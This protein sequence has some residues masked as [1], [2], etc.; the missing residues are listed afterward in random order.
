[1]I[2]RPAERAGLQL[3]NGLV[4]RILDDTGDESGNLALMVY[5]LDELYK[6]SGEGYIT[7]ADYDALGGVQGG[8]GT[9]A[10]QVYAAL[11]GTEEEKA[12]WMQ[13]IFHN[14]V[15]V[16]ERGTP[17]RRRVPDRRIHENDR[18]WVKAFVDARL[19]TTGAHNDIA[20]L[21]VAHEALFRSWNRLKEWIAEAQED[22][23]L[24]RQLRIV[25]AEWQVQNRPSYLLWPQQ[26]LMLIYA[27]QKRLHP[28][29]SDVEHAFVKNS[30]DVVQSR[31]I[32]SISSVLLKVLVESLKK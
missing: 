14:L 4:K 32:R 20:V 23:I 3:E 12:A 24:L 6:I 9:R 28:E 7:H 31:R 5:A 25:A 8:I 17:T 11:L 27:M 26:R 21:E 30:A 22:L 1:M 15:T 16:D 10:E 18:K 13:R 29:L 19:L 2:E